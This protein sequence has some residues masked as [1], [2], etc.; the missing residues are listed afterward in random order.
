MR[1]K[2]DRLLGSIVAVISCRGRLSGLNKQIRGA[3]G[4]MGRKLG[5]R[6]ASLSIFF[7]NSPERKKQKPAHAAY[8][9]GS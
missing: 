7:S 9:M 6:V 2:N 5:S 1:T 4:K 3:D 8:M